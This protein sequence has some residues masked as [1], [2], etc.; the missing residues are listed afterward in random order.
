MAETLV[1][2]VA[3]LVC[4]MSVNSTVWTNSIIVHDSTSTGF[5]GGESPIAAF[6]DFCKANTPNA[7]FV[8]EIIGYEVFQTH[9]GETNVDHPPLFTNTYHVAGTHDTNYNGSPIGS[10]LPKDVAVFAKCATSGGRAGKMFVR[11]LLEESD[12]DSAVSGTWEF[13]SGSTR[14]TVA[15]FATVVTNTMADQLPGGADIANH[16]WCVVH[17]Q[18]TKTGDTRAAYQTPI[19]GISAIRPVWNKAHR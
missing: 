2:N 9:E 5:A 7:G 1:P 14:F 12:V 11:N 15:R 18:H 8:E 13:S 10:P 17:L 3:R 16:Q 4:H 19:S 6:R